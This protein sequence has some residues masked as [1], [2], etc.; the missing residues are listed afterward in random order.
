VSS[1]FYELSPGVYQMTVH[2]VDQALNGII[3]DLE[4]YFAEQ[5][6]PWTSGQA[7]QGP[8]GWTTMPVTGGIGW[9][10]SSSPLLTCHPVTFIFQASPSV[11]DAIWVHLTD[12]EHRNL[13]YIISQR[14][15]RPGVLA[16]E[17]QPCQAAGPSSPLAWLW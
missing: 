1:T 5:Q 11:G 6:P 17:D 4:I 8:P 2:V 12:R 16:A 7:L 15:P 10:T 14:V 13:G 3:F 9:V